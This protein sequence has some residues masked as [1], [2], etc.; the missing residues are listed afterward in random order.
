MFFVWNENGIDDFARKIDNRGAFKAETTKEALTKIGNIMGF[1]NPLDYWTES[2]GYIFTRGVLVH[3]ITMQG[4]KDEA[5]SALHNKNRTDKPWQHKCTDESCHCHHHPE[6][7]S[8]YY[9]M[10]QDP[11]TKE[12]VNAMKKSLT[13]LE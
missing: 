2:G 11:T 7:D 9:L 12:I 13:H 8:Y 6:K 4:F 10:S 1:P 3:S 5:Q